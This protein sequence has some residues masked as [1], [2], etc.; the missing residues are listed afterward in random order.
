MLLQWFCVYSKAFHQF[1]PRTL[2]ALSAKEITIYINPETKLQPTSNNNFY[3]LMETINSRLPSNNRASFRNRE[4]SKLLILQAD[5]FHAALNLSCSCLKLKCFFSKCFFY[6]NEKFMTF[7]CSCLVLE[8]FFEDISKT[9]EAKLNLEHPTESWENG[10][11]AKVFEKSF[12]SRLNTG[13][14]WECWKWIFN[15]AMELFMGH[16]I[17]FIDKGG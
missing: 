4:R 2:Q 12:L 15:D 14:M 1:K 3:W 10:K 9:K 5:N 8:P 17:R 11:L 13:T 6:V 16:V 7:F